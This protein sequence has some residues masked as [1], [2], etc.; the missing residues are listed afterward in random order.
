MRVRARMPLTQMHYSET[1]LR[2]TARQLKLGPYVA[3]CQSLSA[4]YAAAESRTGSVPLSEHLGRIIARWTADGYVPAPS[5]RGRD[6]KPGEQLLNAPQ[7]LYDA[8]HLYSES[9][10]RSYGQNLS[11][12]AA[13]AAYLLMNPDVQT[14]AQEVEPVAEVVEVVME[15]A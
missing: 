8:G 10:S 7:A 6:Y 2:S 3:A 9:R 12:V 11:L 4:S 13:A 1:A 5:E 14:E 15:A